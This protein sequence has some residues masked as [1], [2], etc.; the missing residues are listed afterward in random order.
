MTI[1][2]RAIS[3]IY[4]R[5]SLNIDEANLDI[6]VLHTLSITNSNNRTKSNPP[7]LFLH[8]FGSTKEDYADALLDPRLHSHPIL[9]YDAPGCG[10]STC[11]DLTRISI[12]FLVRC[13]QAILAHYSVDSFHVVGHSMGG[14]T[15]L[16]LAHAEGDRVLSFV[17]IEGNLSPEDCFLSRQILAHPSSCPQDFMTSFTERARLDPQRS[18]ALYAANV[19]SKVRAEAVRGIFESM[20]YLSDNEDLMGMFTALRGQKM[21]MYGEENRGL[22]YL[23]SLAKVGVSVVEIARSGHWPMYSNPVAM[24]DSIAGFLEGAD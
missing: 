11:S 19:A 9:A 24:W 5:V 13:A 23:G 16:L 17:D 15:A 3:P 7:I 12:P 1:D 22:S 10:I 21:F 6:S 20:V 14:L 18:S 4:E 8:G 2:T